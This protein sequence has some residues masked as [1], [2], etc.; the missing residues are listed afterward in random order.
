VSE[1]KCGPCPCKCH[2][3][4]RVTIRSITRGRPGWAFGVFIPQLLEQLDREET[5]TT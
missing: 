5:P 3:T 1:R 2:K 4:Q